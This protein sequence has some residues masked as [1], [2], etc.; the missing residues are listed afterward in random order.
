MNASRLVGVFAL[1]VPL[2]LACA[3]I[4][5]EQSSDVA[6]DYYMTTE[7]TAPWTGLDLPIQ[8]GNIFVSTSNSVTIQYNNGPMGD[9]FARY[10]AFF[11]GRGFEEF[12]KDLS[13]DTQTIIYR[14]SS[15]QYT[16]SGISVAGVATITIGVSTL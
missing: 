14:D 2:A 10:Q 4:Q 1:F 3:G 16:M 11:D 9:H 12:F 13:G 15:E 7:L 6:G 8:G 5:D